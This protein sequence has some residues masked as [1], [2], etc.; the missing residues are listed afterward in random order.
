MPDNRIANENDSEAM[1]SSENS[2]SGADNPAIELLIRRAVRLNVIIMGLT[3]GAGAGLGLFFGTHLSLAVSG[4]HAGNFLNL[5]GVFFPGYSASP[6]GAWIGLLWGSALGGF[7]GSY[8]YW[9]YSRN[10]RRRLAD[11]TVQAETTGF[12]GDRPTAQ[13]SGQSL[14]LAFGSL[15]ALQLFLTTMWLV[16]RGAGEFS[17]HANLLSNYLPGYS[18]SFIGALIGCLEIFVFTYVFAWIFAGIY[19]AVATKRTESRV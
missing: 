16:V 14:G 2:H 7:S 1:Q 15:L 8:G 9:L 18:V 17:P 3:I 19:N 11:M 4:E 10:V 6:S 5:L 13:L 12:S